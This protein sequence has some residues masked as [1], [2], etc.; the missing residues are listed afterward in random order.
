MT[1]IIRRLLAK[2]PDARFRSAADLLWTLEQIDSPDGRAGSPNVTPNRPSDESVA[3]RN[4]EA[5]RQ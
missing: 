4:A 1:A 5:C 3:A 2:A